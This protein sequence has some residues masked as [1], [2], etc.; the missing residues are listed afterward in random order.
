MAPTGLQREDF[1]QMGYYRVKGARRPLRF[2]P[3]DIAL[4]TGADDRGEFLQ[5]R[6][7]LDPGCYATTL[8]RE[9]VKLDSLR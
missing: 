1:R 7:T 9:I 2:Q 5:L 6:F 4:D 3:Q 8:L